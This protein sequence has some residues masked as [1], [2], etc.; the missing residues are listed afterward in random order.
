MQDTVTE[1]E[2][3]PSAVAQAPR[4]DCLLALAS[5]LKITVLLQSSTKTRAINGIEL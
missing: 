5:A 2:S 3:L 1:I 4:L